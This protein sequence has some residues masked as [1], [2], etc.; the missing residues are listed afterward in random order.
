[1]ERLVSANITPLDDQHRAPLPYI[2]REI[3]LKR[4][5]P[6]QKVRIGIVG[7]SEGKPSGPNAREELYAGYRI[8][9]PF[10]AA[11]KVLPE[12]KQK[13]DFIVALAYYGR[14]LCSTSGHRK[15]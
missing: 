9:D 12:L 13:T 4:G 8:N 6:G 2:V 1:M 3:A 5:A 11:R 10:E 14:A 7:F 15:P